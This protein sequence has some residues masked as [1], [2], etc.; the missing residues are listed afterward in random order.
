MYGSVKRQ[1]VLLI[2]NISGNLVTFAHACS[3]EESQDE[4]RLDFLGDKNLSV[5]LFSYI[6]IFSVSVSHI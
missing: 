2:A 1:D 6:Y 3:T 5:F 4:M